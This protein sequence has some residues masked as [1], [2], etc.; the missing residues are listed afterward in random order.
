MSI[1]LAFTSEEKDHIDVL[2]ASWVNFL[3]PFVS[4]F[5]WN[6]FAIKVSRALK[7]KN[8]ICISIRLHVSPEKYAYLVQVGRIRLVPCATQLLL[9]GVTFVCFL[10]WTLASTTPKAAVAL[11]KC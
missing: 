7:A 4:N 10:L 2:Q 1:Q 3:C 11:H 5:R 8:F 9:L 6:S